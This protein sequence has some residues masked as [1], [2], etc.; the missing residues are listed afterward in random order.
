MTRGSASGTPQ[1]IRANDVAS[2]LGVG[3]R[4]VQQMAAAGRLPSAARIGKVWTF[5]P[6][7][8]KSFLAEAEIQCQKRTSIRETVSGGFER[9]LTESKSERA[10]ELAMS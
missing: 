2:I 9:P 4:C 8:I 3:V 5:D 1:R 7:R 10:Y 6:V